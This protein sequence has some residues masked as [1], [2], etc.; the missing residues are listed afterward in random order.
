MGVGLKIRVFTMI[1]VVTPRPKAVF[2]S[3]L[4]T[5]ETNFFFFFEKKNNSLPISPWT[6]EGLIDRKKNPN[7]FKL[8]NMFG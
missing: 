3:S 2:Q 7:P 4:T 5:P 8:V 6:D 1:K